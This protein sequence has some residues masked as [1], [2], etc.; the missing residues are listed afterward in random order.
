MQKSNKSIYSAGSVKGLL[1]WIDYIGS[2]VFSKW[3]GRSIIPFIFIRK[4]VVIFSVKLLN[5][6]YMYINSHIFHCRKN[7]EISQ[8]DALNSGTTIYIITIIAGI[9]MLHYYFLGYCYGMR[10]RVAMCSLIYRKVYKIL[11]RHIVHR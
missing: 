5:A 9:I 10:V 11:S 7:T 1:V 3:C 6:N 4:P 8:N 2:F